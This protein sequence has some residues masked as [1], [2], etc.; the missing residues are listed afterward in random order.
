MVKYGLFAFPKPVQ[1]ANVRTK[2]TAQ[3][4]FHPGGIRTTDFLA[5][6]HQKL[7]PGPAVIARIPIEGRLG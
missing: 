3:H 7:R 1:P 2:K 4:L 6:I 5:N